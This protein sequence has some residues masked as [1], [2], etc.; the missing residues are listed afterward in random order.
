MM[1]DERR[2]DVVGFIARMNEGADAL[3]QELGVVVDKHLMELPDRQGLEAFLT[4]AGHAVLR[5]SGEDRS[6]IVTVTFT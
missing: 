1:A 6:F 4:D 3:K 5:S 2:F